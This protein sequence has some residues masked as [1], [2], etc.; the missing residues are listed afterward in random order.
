MIEVDYEK[1]PLKYSVLPGQRVTHIFE[2]ERGIDRDTPGFVDGN[3]YCDERNTRR[4]HNW[5][6]AYLTC[7]K[8]ARHYQA[9]ISGV[10][11]QPRTQRI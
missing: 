9:L 7:E 11:Q 5:K 3:Y 10:N 2:F 8:C 1:L 6:E 4:A